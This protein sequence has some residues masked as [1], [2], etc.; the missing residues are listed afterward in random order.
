MKHPQDMQ[1]CRFEKEKI[2]T[3]RVKEEVG[4]S[5]MKI[6]A[7]HSSRLDKFVQVYAGQYAFEQADDTYDNLLCRCAVGVFMGILWNNRRDKS[8]I[9]L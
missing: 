4:F 2:T 8:S 1:R 9:S 3:K 5:E 7:E 6:C